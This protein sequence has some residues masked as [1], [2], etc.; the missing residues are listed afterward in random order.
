[1]FWHFGYEGYNYIHTYAHSHACT[2]SHTNTNTH[3]HMHTHICTYTHT[4]THAYTHIRTHTRMHTHSSSDLLIVCKDALSEDT[5]LLLPEIGHLT[6]LLEKVTMVLVTLFLVNGWAGDQRGCG[7]TTG[8]TSSAPL[9]ASD[10][11]REAWQRVFP[12]LVT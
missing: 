3:T 7:R 10:K 6:A 11:T 9:E 2:H 5:V 12:F 4:H 1:M 8:R